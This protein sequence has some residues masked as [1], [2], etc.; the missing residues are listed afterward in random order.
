M[1]SEQALVITAAFVATALVSYLIGRSREGAGRERGR[2]RSTFSRGPDVRSPDI[3][4]IFKATINDASVRRRLLDRAKTKLPHANEAELME[5][6]LAD[7]H[8]DHRS[9]R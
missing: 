6:V 5:A 4:R 2:A 9:W 1:T 7:Y 3:D 8:R